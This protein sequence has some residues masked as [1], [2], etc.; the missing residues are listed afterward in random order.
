MS[1]PAQSL[2]HRCLLLFFSFFQPYTIPTPTPSWAPTTVKA[3]CDLAEVAALACSPM[4]GS[5]QAV[6]LLEQIFTFPRLP[7]VGLLSLEFL[8]PGCSLCCRWPGLSL[9]LEV[10]VLEAEPSVSGSPRL[11]ACEHRGVSVSSIWSSHCLLPREES[12]PSRE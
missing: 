12:E 9:T 4:Q 2:A 3:A 6:L 5:W 11:Q 1:S 7:P 10:W 8:E